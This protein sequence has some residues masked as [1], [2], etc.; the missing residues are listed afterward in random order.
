MVLKKQTK[1]TESLNCY[2][3]VLNLKFLNKTIFILK[4]DL[5]KMF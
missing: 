2:S 1:F 5:I 4:L 3:A